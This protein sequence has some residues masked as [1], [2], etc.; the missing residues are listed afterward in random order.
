MHL[1]VYIRWS[2][3]ANMRMTIDAASQTGRHKNI[4]GKCS[5]NINLIRRRQLLRLTWKNIM[6]HIILRKST[7][8]TV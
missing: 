3:I 8:E 6:K 7:I 1:R 5:Q 2:N 4:E